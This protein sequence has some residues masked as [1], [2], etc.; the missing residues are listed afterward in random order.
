MPEATL[1]PQSQGLLEV[2]AAAGLP[3]VIETSVTQAR[4]R[5]RDEF[6][7]DAPVENVAIVE[8]RQLATPRGPFSIRLYR[9]MEG[10]LPLVMFF[11]GGGWCLNDLDTYD[12]TCRRLANACAAVVISVGFRRSPEHPFPTQ[13]ED[14]FLATTWAAQHATHIG[15]DP[16]RIG[17]V[18]DS[19]GGTN[20][21]VVSLL[22]RDRGFPALRM[23]GLLYPVTDAPSDAS[24]SYEERGTGY[25]LDSPTMRWFW[26]HYVGALTGI[27]LDDPY[28]CPLRA[29]DLS[30]LP[31]GFVATA[32]FDPLRDEGHR[33]ADRLR[34]EGTD[35]V[36]RHVPD[37]MHNFLLQTEL[38]ARAK[39]EVAWIFDQIRIHLGG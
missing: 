28:L 2:A 17:V 36:H 31:G 25:V 22:A 35:I 9:P 23:Q 39:E 10:T 34:A 30:H 26:H 37:L 5:L 15:I 3:P 24:P 33:Y 13:V 1:D 29:T 4:L 7:T 11:H 6:I 8:E 38:I 12:R 21:A 14:C 19:S 16:E 27:D 32:E 18:G 20:A